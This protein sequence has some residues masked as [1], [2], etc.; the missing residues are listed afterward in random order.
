MADADRAGT[1]DA[2]L[3]FCASVSHDDFRQAVWRKPGASFN[4]VCAGIGV[5]LK[6]TAC[7][8]NAESLYHTAQQTRPAGSSE[9]RT[10]VRK[11]ARFTRQ[12]LYR[13]IDRASPRISTPVCEVVPVFGGPGVETTLCVANSVSRTIGPRSARFRL[14]V[15]VFDEAGALR[16]T[17]RL[18][19]PVGERA[20]LSVS[21]FLPAGPEG[22]P[23]VGSC[24][25]DRSA[26]DDAYR[27]SI[28]THF[29]VRTP[30]ATT[31]LHAQEPNQPGPRSFMT[32]RRNPREQQSLSL[33]NCSD[34]AATTEISVSV[35]GNDALRQDLNVQTPAHGSSLVALPV[36]GS[37]ADYLHLVNLRSQRYFRY[38]LLIT[39]PDG[40]RLSLDHV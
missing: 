14:K 36:L 17:T 15:R 11:G 10:E 38:H 16:H 25:V 22:R 34:E 2:L 6:C 5:G 7:L 4:E 40:S 39:G 24:W 12:G 23:A 35:L 9:A 32:S 20:D 1:A 3:C 21:P 37:E 29:M 26:L 8:L 28:R 30:R 19:L 18:T 33:V 31:A 27:G 13:L